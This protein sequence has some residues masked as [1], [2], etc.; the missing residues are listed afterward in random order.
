MEASGNEKQ[1]GI[2]AIAFNLTMACLIAGAIIAVTYYITNPIAVQKN[3]LLN[4]QA[5]QALVPD[6]ESFKKVDGKEGW[7]SA[8]KNNNLLAYIVP[9]DTKGF[10]GSIKMLVAVTP[11]GKEIDFNIVQHNE[12]PGLGDNARKDSF[13]AQ[14]H[15][16]DS[17]KMVVVK[18]PAN[19]ENIQAM[20]GATITSRA[21]T[22]GVKEAEDDVTALKGG[23]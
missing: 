15:G 19:H 9:I 17:S 12:T 22:K 7:Y 11:D 2:L 4:N 10:G 21:V 18:D 3:I 6:A 5:M 14:F 8:Q 23:N 20:T 1:Y 13:R 16:K